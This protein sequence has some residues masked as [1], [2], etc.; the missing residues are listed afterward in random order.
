MPESDDAHRQQYR[1][2][3]VRKAEAF[4]VPVEECERDETK[5]PLRERGVRLGWL[6]KFVSEID[7]TIGNFWKTYYGALERSKW[8]DFEPE[9]PPPYS[10]TNLLS[11]EFVELFVKPLTFELKVALYIRIPEEARGA[12]TLFVSHTWDSMIVSGGHASLDVLLNEHNDDYIWVDFC[13]Y[14]QHTIKPKSIATDME[15]IISTS[16]RRHLL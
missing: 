4:L 16:V 11:R 15:N 8:F 12:P 10:E 2:L 7:Q 5:Y 1:D 14:N 3:L 9:P 6:Y 13:C